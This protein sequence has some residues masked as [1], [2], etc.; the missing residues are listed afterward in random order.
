MRTGDTAGMH[1]EQHRTVEVGGR[2]VRGG[3]V[4]RIRAPAAGCP[5]D[6]TSQAASG[7]TSASSPGLGSSGW[8]SRSWSNGSMKTRV[9]ARASRSTEPGGKGRDRGR[10]TAGPPGQE[11]LGHRLQLEQVGHVVGAEGEGR[12]G[13]VE[14]GPDR[15]L[16]PVERLLLV[17]QQPPR[18]VAVARLAQPFHGLQE[19]RVRVE[20]GGGGGDQ[21]ARFAARRRAPAT[22]T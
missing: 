20:L 22:A 14:S 18:V 8:P 9:Q 12:A 10:V 13:L 15:Q 2:R 3:G 16:G 1:H 4:G 17:G 19:H 11:E 6:H 21:R 7:R 5:P